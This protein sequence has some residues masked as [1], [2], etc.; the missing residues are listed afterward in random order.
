MTPRLIKHKIADSQD[1]LSWLELVRPEHSLD[2][3]YNPLAATCL[4]AV[5]TDYLADLNRKAENLDSFPRGTQRHFEKVTVS[6]QLAES[7]LSDLRT[8]LPFE[9]ATFDADRE[10]STLVELVAQYLSR[11]IQD[12][13]VSEYEMSMYMDTP[14]LPLLSREQALSLT[15]CCSL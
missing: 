11:V 15:S 2:G 4:R 13:K 8:S 9:M 14:C 10:P 5:V 1:L 6:R 7:L 3:S 12:L